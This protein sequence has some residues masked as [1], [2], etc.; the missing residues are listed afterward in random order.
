MNSD[1]DT[2]T[3]FAK[4]ALAWVGAMFGSLTLSNIALIMTIIFTGLQIYKIVREIWMRRND[5]D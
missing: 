3:A 5:R 4:I 2:S 1:H